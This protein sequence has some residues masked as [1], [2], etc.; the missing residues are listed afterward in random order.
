MILLVAMVMVIV[1]RKVMVRMKV[2]IQVTMFPSAR[3]MGALEEIS[4]K[5]L[6]Q[7]VYLK[8]KV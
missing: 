1:L 2:M 3:A 6:E 7:L 4:G 5:K 8:E